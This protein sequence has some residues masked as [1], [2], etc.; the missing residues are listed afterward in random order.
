M[1]RI[2]I[3]LLVILALMILVTSYRAFGMV[4][5]WN[6]TMEKEYLNDK[7][8]RAVNLCIETIWRGADTNLENSRCDTMLVLAWIHCYHNDLQACKDSRLTGMFE[9][10]GIR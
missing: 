1:I 9:Y 4:H 6:V 5:D 7:I 2:Y 10:F 3:T 8:S